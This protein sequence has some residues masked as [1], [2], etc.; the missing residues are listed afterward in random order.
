[1]ETLVVLFH[2]NIAQASKFFSSH[3]SSH[4]LLLVCL[5]CNLIL[6]FHLCWYIKM[7]CFFQVFWPQCVSKYNCSWS[8]C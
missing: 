1:M 3:N 7:D 2:I 8:Q 4:R 5:R 6:S